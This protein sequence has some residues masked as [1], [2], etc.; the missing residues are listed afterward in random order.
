[1][2]FRAI[3]KYF[4][5][6]LLPVFLFFIVC[7][8][9]F[10]QNEIKT[11]ERY[12][13][14]YQEKKPKGEIYLV[15]EFTEHYVKLFFNNADSCLIIVVK[16]HG[17]RETKTV[18]KS[19]LYYN[20]KTRL[21]AYYHLLCGAKYLHKQSLFDLFIV[22]N[23][24]NNGAKISFSNKDRNKLIKA[25][26]LP[27]GNAT[28]KQKLKYFKK[29]GDSQGQLMGYTREINILKRKKCSVKKR[30]FRKEGINGVKEMTY[31]M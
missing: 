5:K 4:L 20:K 22:S 19:D 9:S 2:T 8:F 13:N 12:T 30:E 16:P 31:G 26:A 24:F 15:S 14:S 23:D 25:Y 11:I 27:K 3:M 29:T 21:Y 10:S 17:N 6:I 28:N 1:M 7:T 18:K